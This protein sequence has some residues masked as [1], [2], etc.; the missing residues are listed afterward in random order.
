MDGQG[1]RVEEVLKQLLEKQQDSL[2]LLKK[3]VEAESFSHDKEGINKLIGILKRVFEVF[4]VE[5]EEV[6][7]QEIGNHLKITW[8]Q[9]PRQITILS[10][11]DTVYPRGTLGS[12]PFRF[13][14][15]KVYGPGVY[16][17]KAS[18]VMMYHLFNLLEDMGPLPSDIKILWLLTSDEEVGSPHGK[19]LVMGEAARSEAVLVLEPSGHGGALKTARKGG[20]KFTIEVQGIAA[21]AGVNP[22]DGANAIEELCRHLINITGFA[23]P[24]IGTTIN[25]G[26]IKGGTLFNV[27][28]EHASAEVDVRVLE[29]EEGERVEQAFRNLSSFNAKTRLTVKGSMYRP[30]MPRSEETKRLFHVASKVGEQL[31]LSLTEVTTGGGSDGNFAASAG[32]PVLD[33]L[34]V[35]G[36][37]AHSPDEYLWLDS[38]EERTALLYGIILSLA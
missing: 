35:V 26:E 29:H 25:I 27:V 12:M 23:D 24:S 13:E 21:H 9:G 4:P 34:G 1:M 28:P 36:G 18:Y 20:G 14:D 10:H 32:A 8:G 22:E 31:G 6:E 38:L 19:T 15:G 37:F 17:M 11:L 16:D 30:P 5:I 3:F 33:G 7:E 2:T